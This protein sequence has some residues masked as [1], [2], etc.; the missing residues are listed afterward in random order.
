MESYGI[1]AWSPSLESYS[2]AT[3][4]AVGDLSPPQAS[5]QLHRL[6]EVPRNPSMESQHGVLYSAY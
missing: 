2:I 4:A 6:L 3:A 1:L 5:G